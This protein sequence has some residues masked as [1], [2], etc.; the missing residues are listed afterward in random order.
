MSRLSRPTRVCD[1]E[2][3]T[4]SIS[5]VDSQHHTIFFPESP[6]AFKPVPTDTYPN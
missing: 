5:D 3:P 1:S 4:A 2:I 6:R